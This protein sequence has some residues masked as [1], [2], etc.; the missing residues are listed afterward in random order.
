MM[1]AVRFAWDLA[2]LVGTELLVHP[3]LG[4]SPLPLDAG[5]GNTHHLSGL[6]HIETGEEAQFHDARLLGIHRSQ[7]IKNLI[8][9]EHLLQPV[10][11]NQTLSVDLDLL[12][13]FASAFAGVPL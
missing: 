3:S 9:R 5:I 12:G 11:R 4:R 10:V 6:F 2:R 7:P 8:E 1:T 13:A